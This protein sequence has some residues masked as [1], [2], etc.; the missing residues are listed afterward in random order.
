MNKI[1]SLH[2]NNFKFFQ[3]EKPIIIDS[4]NL[5]L[6]GENGSGKS[7]IY[8]A[9]YTLFEA[10]LKSEDDN[11][12]KYFSKTIK[13]EDNLINIHAKEDP[14]DPDNYNSFIE[15]ITSDNPEKKY[16][17]SKKDFSINKSTDAKFT[18]YASDFI[19]YRMLLGISA[20]RHSDK[21][22]LFNVFVEDIFKYVQF[23]KVKITR[24]GILKE[25]TN[26]F[27]IWQQIEQGHEIVD[28]VGSSK[29]RKIRAYK[30][31]DL[32]K[33]FEALVKSFN[34]SLKK[35]IDYI[36]VQAPIYFKR[37]GYNF[38][39][40]L[41]LEKEAYYIKGDTTYEPVPFV[42][43]LNIPEYENE[44]DSVFKPHSFLNE[45]KLSAIAI[46]IRLAILSEKRQE[47]CLK[48]I[49][50]DDLLI[51]LDMRN[52]E[53]VLDLL[54]SSEFVDNY[55]LLILTHDR[56]FYQMA[57]HKIKEIQQTSWKYYEMFESE[58]NGICKPIILEE[59]GYLG[60]AISF[61]N[62]C[63][64]EV[65]ANFLRKEAEA[66]CKEILPSR[67]SLKN[68]GNYKDLNSLIIETVAF[69]KINGINAFLFETLD[70]HRKFILNPSS[71]DSYDVPKYKN[72]IQ[73]CINNLIEIRRILFQ[74]VIKN[75]AGLYFEFTN[76]TDSYR[77][78]I[79]ICEDIKLIKEPHSNSFLPKVFINYNIFENGIKT[80]NNI[81]HGI[82]SIKSMH[83][84]F[85]NWS[86]KTKR[87]D[88]WDNVIIS[89]TGLPLKSIKVF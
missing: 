72:E 56:M 9:L 13:V 88:Y 8:W 60:K 64:M 32:W 45:A 51:S 39:F 24:N 16:R 77:I 43:R 67:L 63:E 40:H 20:F 35:K 26:A 55:Q 31:S 80:K 66:F 42:L 54:L 5:L 82:Y 11:I 38:P 29:P 58:G 75:D 53:R 74:T 21:I 18:N 81:Q 22:D 78:E 86:D 33:E 47:N 7:S 44:I 49:V 1:K 15:L 83:D 57:K 85:Y 19:N 76:G 41:T 69:A 2:I 59:I 46:S 12:K 4:K 34:D 36:N 52:R 79:T 65:S 23:S 62:Q 3:E 87:A 73:S 70:R 37:L 14:I 28:S 10:S 89:G 84:K 6:Y 71:H 50:L 61:L 48:F 30:Y 17:I 68:D 27:E 25:F